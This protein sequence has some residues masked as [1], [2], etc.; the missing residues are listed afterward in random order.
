M[1]RI[2]E[3]RIMELIEDVAHYYFGMTGDT[4]WEDLAQA[5]EAKRKDDDKGGVKG[6]KW[7]RK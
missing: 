3:R 1:I 4:W 7:W 5:V 6:A 2:R